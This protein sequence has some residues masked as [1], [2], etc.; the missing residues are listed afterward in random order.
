MRLLELKA[1]GWLEMVEPE[2]IVRDVLLEKLDL[3][4]ATEGSEFRGALVCGLEQEAKSKVYKVYWA[5]G[6]EL[7]KFIQQSLSKLE[8]FAAMS[9][10]AAVVVHGRMGWQKE[11]APFGYGS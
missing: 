9:G 4:M 11:L 2:E 3:W 8:Q 1:G 7:D 10:A 6:Y 5:G